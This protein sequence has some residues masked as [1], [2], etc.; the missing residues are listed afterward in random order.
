MYIDWRGGRS[1]NDEESTR[2]EPWGV[3][4]YGRE[5]ITGHLGYNFKLVAVRCIKEPSV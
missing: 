3:L 2:K 1:E 5:D 4:L